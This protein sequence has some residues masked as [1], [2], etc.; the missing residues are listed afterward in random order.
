MVIIQIITTVLLPVISLFEN[1][2]VALVEAVVDLD[3]E[4]RM[5][6]DP[7]LEKDSRVP[8]EVEVGAEV[9]VVVCAI[10]T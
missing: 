1:V 7:C 2:M 3:L 10:Y 6:Y 9:L 4:E 8:G 5:F